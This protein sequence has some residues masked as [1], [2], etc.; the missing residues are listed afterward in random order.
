MSIIIYVFFHYIVWEKRTSYFL[1]KEKSEGIGDLARLSYK[2]KYSK[3]RSHE[4]YKKKPKFHEIFNGQKNLDIITIG[5]SFS[6][7]GGPDL[8][9]YQDFIARKYNLTI[10]NLNI[11][12]NTRSTFEMVIQEDFLRKY[13]PKV[14]IIQTVQREFIKKFS[15]IYEEVEYSEEYI[16]DYL[17]NNKLKK[18]KNDKRKTFDF[19]T[20]LNFKAIL[21]DILYIFSENAFFSKVYIVDMKKNL[22]N[23]VHGNKLLFY[24][25]DLEG[26]DDSG[27]TKVKNAIK[28]L[29]TYADKLAKFEVKL[30]LLIVPDKYHV[31]KKFFHKKISENKLF[32]CIRNSQNKFEFIN[33]DILLEEAINGEIKEVYSFDDT[34]W[35]KK[36]VEILFNEDKFFKEINKNNENIN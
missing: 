24:Y 1:D 36:A 10:A 11:S 17:F 19:I 30:V 5:D 2:L 14:V 20:N 4:N 16:D 28:N 33:S 15:K 26:H 35:T 32:D 29:N 21:F 23:H 13:Y 7:G 3:D 22:F 34:H 31:Y 25:K 27:C 8:T 9:Y 12:E 6:S 18:I